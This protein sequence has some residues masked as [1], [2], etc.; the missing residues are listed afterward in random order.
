MRPSLSKVICGFCWLPALSATTCSSSHVS[1]ASGT[2]VSFQ[3]SITLKCANQP[4]I[5]FKIQRR[6]NTRIFR[7]KYF[8]E[9]SSVTP[10]DFSKTLTLSCQDIFLTTAQECVTRR[11]LDRCRRKVSCSLHLL[12]GMAT[13]SSAYLPA[14]QHCVWIDVRAAFWVP[15]HP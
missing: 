11:W 5:F 9:D 1:G 6:D 7:H 14:C 8:E 10:H 15:K 3:D 13:G 12:R 2:R 4:E